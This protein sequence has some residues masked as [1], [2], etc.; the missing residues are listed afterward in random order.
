MHASCSVALLVLLLAADP[1]KDDPARK[2]L[3]RLQGTW[4]MI[5]LEVDGKPIAED[6]LADTTL[7][8]KGDRYITRVKDQSFETAIKLN[9]AKK[10]AEIDMTFLDGE[11]KDKTALGIYR[12]DGDTFKMCRTRLP[13][14]DRPTEFATWPNSDTFVVTWKKKP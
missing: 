11:N 14:K 9:P 10:P 1:P 6:K 8:I 7:T 5:A 4:T 3:D 13:E 2:E 12:I